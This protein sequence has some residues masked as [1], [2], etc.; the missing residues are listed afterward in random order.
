ML[1]MS[2]RA[3]R[4]RLAKVPL[5]AV[6]FVRLAPRAFFGGSPATPVVRVAALARVRRVFPTFSAFSSVV[7]RLTALALISCQYND[8]T[9]RDVT[10]VG[11]VTGEVKRALWRQ[12]RTGGMLAIAVA[13]AVAIA[14]EMWLSLVY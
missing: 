4:F 10:R 5:S 6:E 2:P 12:T 7:V 13:V 14:D 3:V 11:K 8:Q 1:L 9:R